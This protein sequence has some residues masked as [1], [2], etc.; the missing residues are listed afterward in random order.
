[1]NS[2]IGIQ[3]VRPLHPAEEYQSGG[4]RSRR[5][6]SGMQNVRMNDLRVVFE[7]LT[8]WVLLP[9]PPPEYFEL[10]A[11]LAEVYEGLIESPFDDRL[12]TLDGDYDTSVMAFVFERMLVQPSG[13]DLIEEFLASHPDLSHGQIA[14]AQ[15][16]TTARVSVIEA[17]EAHPGSHFVLKDLLRTDPPFHINDKERLDW[18]EEGDILHGRIIQV[19]ETRYLSP[20]TIVLSSDSWDVLSQLFNTLLANLPKLVKLAPEGTDIKDIGND[21][22][23]E[24][25]QSAFSVWLE[26]APVKATALGQIVMDDPEPKEFVKVVFPVKGK[27]LAHVLNNAK[28]FAAESDSSWIW[29]GT[30]DGFK[31]QFSGLVLKDEELFVTSADNAQTKLIAKRLTRLFGDR[32]GKPKQ[33]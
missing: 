2:D 17:L 28:D 23:E 29:S 12:A 4:D 13:K 16:L 14:I 24:F 5:T 10:L 1:M 22:V 7:K 3:Q 25:G 6:R 9:E 19:G 18:F 8:R 27:G 31:A 20:S 26:E 21:L 11:E 33:S 15:A 30:P 32:L